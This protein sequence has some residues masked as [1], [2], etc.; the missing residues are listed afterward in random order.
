[1]VV[2]VHNLWIF[3]VD[4]VVTETVDAGLLGEFILETVHDAWERLL[5]P[6]ESGGKVIPASATVHACAVECAAVRRQ[7]R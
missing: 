5:L 6:R 7:N 2:I 1:M 4:L 3:R